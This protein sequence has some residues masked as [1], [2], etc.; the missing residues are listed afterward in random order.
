[1]TCSTPLSKRAGFNPAQPRDDLG[2]WTDAGG[3]K[4]R[5]QEVGKD[6]E[7]EPTRIRLAGEIPTND[8][9]ETGD[10]GV[11]SDEERGPGDAFAA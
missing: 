6:G 7:A 1:M 2:K 4:E 10:H 8:P 9:S 5:A 3:D 11:V